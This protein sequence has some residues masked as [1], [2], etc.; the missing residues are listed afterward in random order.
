MMYGDG[1]FAFHAASLISIIVIALPFA[2][3]FYFVAERMG[4]QSL[5]WAAL[6]LIPVVNFFFMIYAIFSTLLYI[7]D[8]LNQLAPRNAAVTAPITSGQSSSPA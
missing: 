8:R 7:L 1:F 3:G 4:R 2:I 5:L 6:I